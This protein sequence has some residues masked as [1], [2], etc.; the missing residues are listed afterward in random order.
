MVSMVSSEFL[1][2]VMHLQPR[3]RVL[4]TSSSAIT[5][6][7]SHIYG[8][9]TMTTTAGT[10]VM[11]AIVEKLR[12]HLTI[13]SVGSLG[14]VFQEVGFVME[15]QIAWGKTTLMSRSPAVSNQQLDGA[16]GQFLKC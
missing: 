14:A 10:T 9:V 15:F 6:V 2:P 5:S 12:V 8:C 4:P 1:F 13:S 16:M 3:W 11:R 7:A